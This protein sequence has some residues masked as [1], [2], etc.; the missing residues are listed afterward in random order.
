MF[1]QGFG[2]PRPGFGGP[3]PRPGFGGPGPQ[4]FQ[5]PQANDDDE[6]E[7]VTDDEGDFLEDENGNILTPQEAEQRGL[8]TKSDGTV[9]RGIGKNLLIGGAVLGGL[10]IMNKQL[11]KK[12]RVKKANPDNVPYKWVKY[13]GNPNIK[14]IVKFTNNLQKTFIIARGEYKNK[15]LHPGYAD[16]KNGKLFTSYGGEEVILKEYEVLTCPQGRLQWQKCTNPQNIKE[17]NTV[18]G[19]Y[20]EDGTPLYVAKCRRDQTEYFGKT[21]KKA[22]C[23]YY[24]L[25]GKEFRINDFE[26]LVWK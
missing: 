1:N 24:G 23:A 25:D 15:G 16:A 20:E 5:Q 14:D 4:G 2:G 11:K 7:Y 9:D 26:V 19:G 6:Y 8:V 21:S 13:T 3:G 12:K 22:Y 10:W 17:A 18:V